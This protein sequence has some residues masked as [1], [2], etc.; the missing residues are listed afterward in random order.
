[1][2]SKE[3]KM[4]AIQIEPSVTLST[5]LW[6][7]SET[8]LLT[9]YCRAI[10]SQSSNPILVDEKAVEI[11]DQLRPVLE[12]S[13]RTGL[14]RLARG[15]ISPT[16]AVH[17][18][19]RAKKY[20]DIAR[21]FLSRNPDGIIVNLGCGMDSRFFRI[22]DGRL[23]FFDLDL[24]EMIDCKCQFFAENERYRMIGASVFETAWMDRV[25]AAGKRQVLFMAEGLFMYLDPDKVRALVPDLQAR[26]PGS[27]LVCEVF[28][29]RWL[30]PRV[31]WMIRS[32]LQ[33]NMKIGAGAVF[34]FGVSDSHEM[35]TWSKGIQLLEEWSYFESDHP[36]L[37]MLKWMG[38]I[39]AM[40]R[41]QWTV[42]YRLGA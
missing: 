38:K 35:E 24:P 10:E 4:N 37:G 12:A 8:G 30:N 18:A 21:D 16:L 13:G 15:K 34:S 42:H 41:V 9:L 20:D 39:K 29:R 14:R 23:L 25:A 3:R 6:D 32:K 27:E 2:V 5:Q 33:G 11:A 31:S 1:M 22:D 19:L 40:R 17:I 28:N 36:K 26:F 7:V